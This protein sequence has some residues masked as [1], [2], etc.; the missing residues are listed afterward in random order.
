MF[1]LERH[2]QHLLHKEQ[3]VKA[4]ADANRVGHV[5]VR[6][7]VEAQSLRTERVFLEGPLPARPGAAVSQTSG[8]S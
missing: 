3:H 4:A 2:L 5:V 6:V 7:G 1:H 8:M